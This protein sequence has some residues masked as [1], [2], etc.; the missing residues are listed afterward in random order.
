MLGDCLFTKEERDTMMTSTMIKFLAI[1]ILISIPNAQAQSVKYG[2][3]PEMVEEFIV[4]GQDP[5]TDIPLPKADIYIRGG[6]DMFTIS[7]VTSKLHALVQANKK[8]ITIYISSPG[9]DVRAM[10]N[11]EQMAALRS[12]GYSFSCYVDKM[13]ASMAFIFLN[14]CDKRYVVPSTKLL[15]HSVS[16]T[17]F[18]SYKAHEL[19]EMAEFMETMDGPIKQQILDATGMP[20]SFYD[21]HD[22]RDTLFTMDQLPQLVENG[23]LQILEKLPTDLNNIS[24]H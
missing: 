14:A 8:N 4:T 16:V 9:G 19:L 21:Y 23:Y 12:M 22:F 20:E 13:A 15:W 18:S 24:T 11:I 7:M 3:P 2:T 1:A 17:L 10:R 6:I 5:Q